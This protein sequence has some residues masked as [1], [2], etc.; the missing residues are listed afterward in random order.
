MSDHVYNTKRIVAV[1]PFADAPFKYAFPTSVPKDV[2][3]AAGHE[4]ISAVKEPYIMGSSH[5][6]PGRI[7]M[8]SGA[9]KG[10]TTYADVSKIAKPDKTIK[11]VERPKTRGLPRDKKALWFYVEVQTPEANASFQ[12]AFNIGAARLKKLGGEAELKKIGVNKIT[13][14]TD[15]R[16]LTYGVNYPKPSHAVKVVTTGDD[17]EQQNTL[18][19]FCSSDKINEILKGSLGDWN[20]LDV[21]Q[22]IL[23]PI[24]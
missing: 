6:K 9:H 7:E 10:V 1:T 17:D 5:P 11:V 20:I 19:V 3:A 13:K 15:P 2:G 23:L 24:E 22:T 21:V 4:D 18:K 14:D 12:Y 16:L 8:V